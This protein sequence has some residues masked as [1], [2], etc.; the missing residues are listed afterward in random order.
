M[1]DLLDGLERAI[2]WLNEDRLE[3]PNYQKWIP[4]QRWEEDLA[5]RPMETLSGDLLWLAAPVHATR[6]VHR[7]AVA[8]KTDGPMGMRMR[9]SFTGECL[10]QWEGRKVDVYFDPLKEWPLDAVIALPGKGTPLGRAVC[11]NPYWEGGTGAEATNALRQVM[12][13]EYRRIWGPQGHF[14]VS[15]KETEIRGPDGV[16]AGESE[17]GLVILPEAQDGKTQDASK[18]PGLGGY[19]MGS[20]FRW[21][22]SRWRVGSPWPEE[23]KPI[24]QW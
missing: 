13:R 18:Q 15:R 10:W 3:S 16:A 2:R 6:T 5:E 4:R 20:N 17:R 21:H 12:R 19:G 11:N 23:H 24:S 7:G 14:D 1:Q 22:G 9:Y 8:V